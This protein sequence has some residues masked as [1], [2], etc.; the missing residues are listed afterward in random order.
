MFTGIVT[1]QA[2]ILS[3]HDGVFTFSIPSNYPM[4]H[5]GQSIAHDGACM[6]VMN[7]TEKTYSFFAMQESLQKTNF[8][9]KVAGD[10]MN[11]EFCVA[12]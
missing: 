8:S 11:I 9:S 3:I 2:A 7:I 6:T 10:L 12:A 4:L 1:H 5:Q